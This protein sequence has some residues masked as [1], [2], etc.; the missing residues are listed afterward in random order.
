[1][2]AA[3]QGEISLRWSGEYAHPHQLRQDLFHSC[4]LRPIAPDPGSGHPAGPQRERHVR[5]VRQ[6]KIPHSMHG[7]S[8]DRVRATGGVIVGCDLK[9]CGM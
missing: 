8:I 7:V 9:V 2:V 1:M 5:R 3:Q 4:T 6:E